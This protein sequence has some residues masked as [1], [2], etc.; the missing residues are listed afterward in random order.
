VTRVDP[1]QGRSLARLRHP[2]EADQPAIAG[3]VDHWFGGRR[4]WPLVARSWFRH[5]AETSWLAE[6]DVGS[7]PACGFLIGYL[8]PAHP[9][10]AILH[11]IAVD[12]NHR[13]RGLGGAL[14]ERFAADAAR[15]GAMS[16][17]AVAWPDDPGAI[18]FF[19]AIGFSPDDAPGTQR[20]YGVPAW[21]DYELPGEDR[22]VL[23]R[24]LRPEDDRADREGTFG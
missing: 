20:L 24:S 18:A 23:I 17:T 22:A 8:S 16:L 19:R 12:P 13:R 21:P 10:E 7:G 15:R 2:T 6:D 11:L 3:V 5:F 4:I 14:V 9:D 1:A